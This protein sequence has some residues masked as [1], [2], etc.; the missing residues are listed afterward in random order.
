[1]DALREKIY[2]H[3]STIT[4]RTLLGKSYLLHSKRKINIP[5]IN[6]YVDIDIQLY[7]TWV[8]EPILISGHRLQSVVTDSNL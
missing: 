4:L 8:Q 1:M 3:F 5:V 7:G 6:I 2:F